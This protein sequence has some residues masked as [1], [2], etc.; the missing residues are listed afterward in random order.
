MEGPLRNEK[1]DDVY[2]RWDEA[3]QKLSSWYTMCKDMYKLYASYANRDNLPYINKLDIP[4]GFKIIETLIPYLVSGMPDPGCTPD[5]MNDEASARRM[6]AKMKHYLSHPIH[7]TNMANWYRDVLQYGT[8]IVKDGWRYRATTT[9]RWVYNEEEIYVAYYASYGE[10]A[11]PA[12]I[13]ALAREGQIPGIEYVPSQ[14]WYTTVD[15]ATEDRPHYEPISPLDFAWLGNADNVQDL[16]C[17]YHVIYKTK[18]EINELLKSNKGRDSD[19]YNLDY[20]LSHASEVITNTVSLQNEIHL[21][22][23]QNDSYRFIEEWRREN[24]EIW[25]TTVCDSAECVVRRRTSPY[26]HG[27]YPFSIIRTFGRG[28]ELV[29]TPIMKWVDSLIAAVVKLGNEILENGSL[30]VNPPFLK[31]PGAKFKQLT[32]ALAAGKIIPSRPD[33]IKQLEIADVRQ[34]SLN[35]LTLFIGFLETITGVDDIVK[36][37]GAPAAANTAGGVEILQFQSTARTRLQQ[38]IDTISMADLYTRMASNIDQYKREPLEIMVPVEG[39]QK[40]KV[41]IEPSDTQGNYK[42]IPDVRSMLATNNSVARAQLQSLL[43]ICVGL[44]ETYKDADGNLSAR[45]IVDIKYLTRKLMSMYDA[46]DNPSKALINPNDTRSIPPEAVG[47]PNQG[48]GGGGANGPGTATGTRGMP[49]QM[50]GGQ[51]P[52]VFSP[53]Q[54][55]MPKK[56]VDAIRS[57]MTIQQ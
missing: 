53:Q 28:R 40:R 48:A 15:M 45:R 38:Y 16:E 33:D 29:G 56:P 39:G 36:G 3:Q 30:A 21:I 37:P 25:I 32:L 8:G 49:P 52:G 50:G 55:P 26:F 44:V 1:Y 31:R 34:G 18:H 54:V 19:Y 9:K 2:E 7:L 23:S 12:M 35:M 22:D 46:V 27:Q 10:A 4:L 43:N 42:F 20:V 57:A 41:R 51:Q 11:A 24:G 17:V 14:G 5:T 6:N 47:P 13:L